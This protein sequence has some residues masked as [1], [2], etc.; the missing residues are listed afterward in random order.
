MIIVTISARPAAHIRASVRIVT[1]R[2][3]ECV[4]WA[5]SQKEFAAS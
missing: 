1:P 5:I 2:H 4:R 3:G